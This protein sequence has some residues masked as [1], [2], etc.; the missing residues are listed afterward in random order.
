MLLD[1][2][3]PGYQPP[4]DTEYIKLN[5]NENAFPPSEKL[6]STLKNAINGR[7]SLYPN[8]SCHDLRK[9]IAKQYNVNPDEIICTN[10]SDESISMIFKTFIEKDDNILLSYPTYSYYKSQAEIYDV[11]YKFIDTDKD[12]NIIL[13]KF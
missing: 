7:I 6:I 10:G 13:D 12:F 2:Y 4:P 11:K 8:S 9:I 3:T 5:T 1:P